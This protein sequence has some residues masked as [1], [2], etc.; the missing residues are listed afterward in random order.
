[1]LIGNGK[2]VAASCLIPSPAVLLEERQQ[3]D[4][5]GCEPADVGAGIRRMTLSI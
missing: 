5:L 1:M 2:I 3:I 4:R